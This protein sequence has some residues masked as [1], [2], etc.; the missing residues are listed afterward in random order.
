[1]VLNGTE[2]ESKYRSLC[3]TDLFRFVKSEE[4]LILGEKFLKFTNYN[5]KQIG[6]E[7]KTI[8]SSAVG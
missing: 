6:K 7:E 8:V 5:K 2:Q 4:A 3:D 1:M